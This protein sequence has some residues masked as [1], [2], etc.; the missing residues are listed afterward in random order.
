MTFPTHILAG[1]I[2]G[3]LTGDYT[4]A[5]TGSLF[6]DLDH[7]ISYHQN[8]IL[9][10]PRA[11]LHESL[12]E[13]DPWGSQKNILHSVQAW[14]LISL[15]LVAINVH[16]GLIFSLA[17]L[18]HLILD[19]LNGDVY[20]FYPYKK[21]QIKKPIIRYLSKKEGVFALCL[22]LVFVFLFII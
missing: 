6:M 20:P 14:L 3:K 2:I 9:F 19:A 12:T 10:K 21:F 16:F 1:L 4:A 8:G 5:L 11:I 17:Y 13:K 18:V 22:S 15:L 7:L